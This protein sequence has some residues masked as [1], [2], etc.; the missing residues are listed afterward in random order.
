MRQWLVYLRVRF[1]RQIKNSIHTPNPIKKAGNLFGKDVAARNAIVPIMD[2]RHNKMNVLISFEIIMR[3]LN[4]WFFFVQ[5]GL[6][7]FL[8][9]ARSGQPTIQQHL[10]VLHQRCSSLFRYRYRS[11]CS[12]DPHD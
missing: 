12:P 4:A 11:L 10:P 2:V 3:L 7:I 8:F 5:L 1:A 9:S 6:L